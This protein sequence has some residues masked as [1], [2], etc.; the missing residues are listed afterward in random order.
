MDERLKQ[1]RMA[2]YPTAQAAAKALG[3]KPDTYT[4]HENGTRG[5]KRESAIQYA[6]KFKVNIEWLLTGKGQKEAMVEP[7]LAVSVPLLSWVSAGKMALEDVSDAYIGSVEQAGLDPKG[8]WIALKVV[9][10]SMDRISPP[11]SV[12][13]V[14]RKDKRLVNNACYVISDGGD[15]SATYKRF[16]GNPSRFEPV[17][18][19]ADHETIFPDNEPIIVG[20]VRRTIL[21]L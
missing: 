4:Q 18:T 3:V 7:L 13:L 14:N 16:R 10:T 12:I 2:L 8:D 17:S 6:K 15:G 1:A 11:Q 9:G 19:E 20:R 21:E 5:F